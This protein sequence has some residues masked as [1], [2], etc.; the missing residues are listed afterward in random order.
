VKIF[1]EDQNDLNKSRTEGNM[2]FIFR[3]LS[4]RVLGFEIIEEERIFA[5]IS[6]LAYSTVKHGLLNTITIKK[7]NR[8]E[9]FIDFRQR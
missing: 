5:F 7:E 6:E 9:V 3:T 8:K 2:H 4:L 1:I